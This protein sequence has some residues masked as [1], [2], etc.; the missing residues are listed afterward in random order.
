MS[1]TYNIAAK[2]TAYRD[3][4]VIRISPL[5]RRWLAHE[6]GLCSAAN[7]ILAVFGVASPEGRIVDRMTYLN[8]DC[9]IWLEDIA[10]DYDLDRSTV[11]PSSAAAAISRQG[12]RRHNGRRVPITEGAAKATLDCYTEE[13]ALLA[14]IDA[15]VATAKPPDAR[16]YRSQIARRLA[17][18]DRLCSA[19]KLAAP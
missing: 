7:T 14:A 11:T 2:P 15:L 10:D 5:H 8:P 9:S 12:L 16:R 13:A 4:S 3:S 18:N 6:C 1:V 19:V 17:A